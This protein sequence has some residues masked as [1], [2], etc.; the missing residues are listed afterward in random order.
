MEALFTIPAGYLHPEGGKVKDV[1]IV[2]GHGENA[3]EWDGPLLSEVAATLAK[4]GEHRKQQPAQR[5]CRHC[6][7]RSCYCQWLAMWLLQTAEGLLHVLLQCGGNMH[8]LR[9]ACSLCSVAYASHEH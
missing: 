9:L 4:A 3:E 6:H 5:W 1:G 7:D 8:H 2:L